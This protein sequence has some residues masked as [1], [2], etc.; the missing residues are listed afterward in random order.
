MPDDD[1]F[2]RDLRRFAS[3]AIERRLATQR[4]DELSAEKQR[5]FLVEFREKM[6]CV[7][8]PIFNEVKAELNGAGFD[9]VDV[10]LFDGNRVSLSLGG[11]ADSLSLVYGIVMSRYDHVEAMISTSP[12]NFRRAQLQL[13]EVTTARVRQDVQTLLSCSRGRM[14]DA[15]QGWNST[16]G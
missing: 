11:D 6:R 8:E 7:V 3:D 15:R 9:G 1:A 16:V 14:P 5:D 2:S 10:D 13:R 4:A 12:H